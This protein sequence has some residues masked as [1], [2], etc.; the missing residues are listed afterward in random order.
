VGWIQLATGRDLVF[1][2]GIN[3]PNRGLINAG[4]FHGWLFY[5]QRFH[6]VSPKHD[7]FDVLLLNVEFFCETLTQSVFYAYWTLPVDVGVDP[8]YFRILRVRSVKTQRI[9]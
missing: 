8:T 2:N 5:Y 9:Y 3:N 7:F 4:E 6:D 1:L